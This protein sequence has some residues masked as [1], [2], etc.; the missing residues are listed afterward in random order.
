MNR[1]NF[2]QVGGIGALGLSFNDILRAQATY[3]GP[4][5]R[6]KS[7]INIFLPGGMSMQ[8]SWDPKP[9][10]PVEYRGPYG[11]INTSTDGIQLSELFPNVAKVMNKATIIRSMTHGEAAHERGVHN[12]FTGWKPS[13]ALQYPAMGS[14]V[15]HEL[16]VRNNLPSYVSIPN[17]ANE[18]DSTGF[19]SSKYGTFGLGSDPADPN[20]KV[21]DL[22]LPDNITIDQFNRR[23]S[24]LETVDNKFKSVAD[25]DNVKAIDE[26]YQRAYNM[27]SSKQAIEAFDLTKEDAK[28]RE[29]Y[30]N[31]QA[32]QRLLMARR[33]IEA[34]TRYVTVTYGGW[35]HHDG[36]Q[37]AMASNAPALD[38]ALSQ[39]LTDL[40][41]RGLLSETLV[42][43]TSEFGRTPK[44]NNTA[45]RD[46]WPRVFSTF[47]AGGPIKR[48]FSYGSSDSL[49]GEV[50]ELPVSP[51]D[52]SATLFNLMGI[53]PDKTL[54]T[55]DLR[56]IT[57][58][59][60]KIITDIIG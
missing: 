19:I 17:Q 12:M 27:I 21:R 55:T 25:S 32:G 56:P 39:L 24:I 47:I 57:I 20:F 1:R 48:G 11:A 36:I 6:V 13:P 37:G 54:M 59:P 2:I 26:F 44:I 3:D 60:G 50:D 58:S 40:D 18:F 41:Q 9:A 4:T 51:G 42:L 23:K 52:I 53:N 43:V 30:G 46:H 16:G 29:E 33:L 49:G 10:A 14:I 7:V 35:D 15:S 45:G 28:V 8:E 38:K 31:N 34:G 22:T 5:P